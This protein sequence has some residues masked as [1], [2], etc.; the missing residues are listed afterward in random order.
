MPHAP[1]PSPRTLT[2][3]LA[4]ATAMFLLPACDDLTDDDP[5]EEE[6]PDAPAEEEDQEANGEIEAEE[7]ARGELSSVPDDVDVTDTEELVEQGGGTFLARCADGLAELVWWVPDEDF[8]VDDVDAGPEDDAE[9]EF[10][11]DTESY[12]YD[13]TCVDDTPQVEVDH[14]D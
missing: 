4:A 1:A 7:E 14:D 10:E 5:A 6:T 13:V 12:E 2:L 3:T 8:H 11:S 9:I